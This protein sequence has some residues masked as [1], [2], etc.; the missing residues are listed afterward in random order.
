MSTAFR[1][2]ALDLGHLVG[3]H[4]RVAQLELKVE[5]HAMVWRVL[6]SAGLAALFAVGYA[7]AMAGL[8]V[9][10]GGN[11]A[12]GI[13]LVAI[14]FVHVLGAGVGLLFAARRKR[15]SHL[16]NTRTTAM[17][18]SVEAL[19]EPRALSIEGRDA[20]DRKAGRDADLARADGELEHVR[21]KFVLSM[22]TVEREVARTLD[23]R[24]W[25]RRRPGLLLAVA[26][27]VGAFFGRR[28]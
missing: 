25:M 27:A 20:F 26:L 3:Q 15:G 13:P 6:I 18:H 24:V 7:L 12:V 1:E 28:D 5:L 11:L 19:K 14:G 8:A 10:I 23:W 2:A 21:E 16:M 22:G 17:I 9:V 4:V